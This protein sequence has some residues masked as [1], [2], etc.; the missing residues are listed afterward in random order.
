[1][2][3]TK[4]MIFEMDQNPNQNS[5]SKKRKLMDDDDDD[6]KSNVKVK[7][8][9]LV[10][11][12]HVSVRCGI[13]YNF[14]HKD[15]MIHIPMILSCGHTYCLL[16][17]TKLM[18]R[19]CPECGLGRNQE[20]LWTPSSL[21]K[22]WSLIHMMEEFFEIEIEMEESD[23]KEKDQP[24]KDHEAFS[25][26]IHI[27]Q[28]YYD[29]KMIETAQSYIHHA[30]K[31]LSTQNKEH[32]K[33][34]F[35][36]YQHQHKISTQLS[37]EYLLVAGRLEYSEAYVNLAYWYGKESNQNESTRQESLY[38][39]L[40]AYESYD[41]KSLHVNIISYIG[42]LYYLMKDYHNAFIWY[43]K[44]SQWND[45]TSTHNMANLYYDGKGVAKDRKKAFELYKKCAS[46]GYVHSMCELGYMYD[47]NVDPEIKQ[48]HIEAVRWLEKAVSANSV[49][50]MYLLHTN[51][52]YGR[53]VAAINLKRSFELC[54]RAADANHAQATHSL[55][56]FYRDGTYVAKNSVRAFNLFEKAVSLGCYKALNCQ[57]NCYE[58]G[59][60][61][62]KNIQLAK[63][64]YEKCIALC[65]NP[66]A[67]TSLA[68]LY[69]FGSDNIAKD[70]NQA[71]KYLLQAV[72]EPNPPY[73]TYYFLGL[74]HANGWGEGV[75][76]NMHT[77]VEYF[78]TSANNGSRAA[79]HKLGLC[80]QDGEGVEK[81]IDKA[82]EWYQ[83]ALIVES[84]DDIHDNF[85]RLYVEKSLYEM[86]L[87][88]YTEKKDFKQS[89]F[90]FSRA[91]TEFQNVSAMYNLGV[92]YC[93]GLGIEKPDISQGLQWIIKAASAGHDMAE[94]C[95]Q[96]LSEF[97]F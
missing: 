59:I 50:A 32:A 52:L 68:H 90:Y 72:V 35:V 29:E 46:D 28:W 1:M 60:G 26:L 71:Y 5:N 85:V 31:I 80:Y 55:G 89:F 74:C 53:G 95:L 58:Y 42:N 77:A 21:K 83:K 91:A 76:V 67:Y 94:K 56:F 27:F 54:Q 62:V 63:E 17:L 47:Y 48:D 93:K 22:N 20:F 43:E 15:N 88:Y 30:S 7:K 44:G 96:N 33:H 14:Y 37:L 13:C 12:E 86:A 64:C 6:I 40:K 87:I 10:D 97:C 38:W 65:N 25:D 16:C 9:K 8:M 3:E 84:D 36:L 45:M 39:W 69:L 18:K 73:A 78:M 79:K 92:H 34:W 57:G 70:V 2:D 4:S 61:V 49:H 41:D 24:L 81:D 66:Y 75:K 11:S 51:Y 82:L 19:N 23:K